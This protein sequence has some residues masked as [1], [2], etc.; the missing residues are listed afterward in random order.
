[1]LVVADNVVVCITFAEVDASVDNLLED[2]AVVV[3]VND[4]TLQLQP[5]LP[6]VQLTLQA[7]HHWLFS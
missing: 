7:A 2:V 3:V 1:V 5:L 4:S 6:G